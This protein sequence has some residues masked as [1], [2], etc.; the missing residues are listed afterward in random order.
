MLSLILEWSG[1][2]SGLAGALLLALN[3]RHSRYGWFGFL[4]ANFV[5]IGFALLGQHW[6]L[7][8]QQIGFT[9]TSLIGIYRSGLFACR[10]RAS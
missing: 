9:L 4:V 3:T 8:T 2:A 7:L 5:M 1:A 10:S 6:G